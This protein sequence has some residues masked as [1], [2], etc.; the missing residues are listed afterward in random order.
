MAQRDSGELCLLLA[1]AMRFLVG[2]GKSLLIPVSLEVHLC[3]LPFLTI[4]GVLVMSLLQKH[5]ELLLQMTHLYVYHG[6]VSCWS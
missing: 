5:V 3:V 4:Q 1:P 2:D 6:C